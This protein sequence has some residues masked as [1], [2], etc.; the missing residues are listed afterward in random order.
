MVPRTTCPR[1]PLPL[2]SAV[3][4][5]RAN[6][7]VS[8]YPNYILPALFIFRTVL[9]ATAF[10]IVS[11]PYPLLPRIFVPGFPST[12][13]ACL[14]P[15]IG[16]LPYYYPF[17]TTTCI[18]TTTFGSCSPPAC[19]P[20]HHHHALLFL[21]TRTY[22]HC[23]FC[24]PTT[25]TDCSFI[26]A[27]HV[28]TYLHYHPVIT[29]LFCRHSTCPGCLLLL[30]CLPPCHTFPSRTSVPYLFYTQWHSG[31]CW[32]NILPPPALPVTAFAVEHGSS[33]SLLPFCCRLV[34]PA[35]VLVIACL[36]R[37]YAVI[38]TLYQFFADVR[39]FYLTALVNAGMPYHS[40]VGCACAA[41]HYHLPT[42]TGL[43]CWGGLRKRVLGFVRSPYRRAPPAAACLPDRSSAPRLKPRLCRSAP[44][45]GRVRARRRFA[46]PLC[47]R[48]Y[49][50]P[51]TA[52]AV[53]R[54]Y[55]PAATPACATCE[56]GSL[57][58]SAFSLLTRALTCVCH[59]ALRYALLTPP[60]TVRR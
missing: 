16:S 51:R 6:N 19:L 54:H 3:T 30:L 2:N 29:L 17:Y 31:G 44:L 38:P 42:T 9:P 28:A 49:L 47:H 39:A 27:L 25:T 4:L 45:P 1:V 20:P 5:F 53:A 58:T 10:N 35:F 7:V 56:H 23:L 48:F 60:R 36:Y 14:P 41:V 52:A 21:D 59:L 57:Y 46:P 12:C 15:L 40:A 33:F 13:S 22:H 8:S 43:C 24:L 32:D 26:P 11:G 37:C 18:C 55:L 50:E 34:S